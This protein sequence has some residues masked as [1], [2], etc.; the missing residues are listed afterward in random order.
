MTYLLNKCHL[1]D[2][3]GTLEFILPSYYVI[4]KIEKLDS[5]KPKKFALKRLNISAE[6]LK[7]VQYVL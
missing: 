6:Y 3:S 7:E 4:V 1:V 5:S 2:L